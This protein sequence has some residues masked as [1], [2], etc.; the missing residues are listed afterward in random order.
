MNDGLDHARSVWKKKNNM[1][2]QTLGIQ[3]RVRALSLVSHQTLDSLLRKVHLWCLLHL[4]LP[5]PRPS[6]L[7]APL[8]L[9][10]LY[11]LLYPLVFAFVIHPLYTSVSSVHPIYLPLFS[12]LFYTPPHNNTLTGSWFPPDSPL[13]P[14]SSP[15]SNTDDSSQG[16]FWSRVSTV[17][18]P[19]HLG[20]LLSRVLSFGAT[21]TINLP[22]SGW[23]VSTCIVQSGG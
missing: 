18:S 13:S 20:F 3:R 11:P 6:L 12:A 23:C 2:S 1:V 8:P 7:M 21:K 10:L 22:G 15:L 5:F 9:S 17:S 4:P 16:P 14:E 19:N